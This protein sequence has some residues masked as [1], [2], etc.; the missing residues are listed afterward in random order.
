MK[1]LYREVERMPCWN[2]QDVID[3]T[4]SHG[5][6]TQAYRMI[7]NRVYDTV[8]AQVWNN[9]MGQVYDRNK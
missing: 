9:V 3:Y 6:N 1:S 7:M 5:V 4:C 2:V 8:A